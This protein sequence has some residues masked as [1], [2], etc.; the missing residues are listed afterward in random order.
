[1]LHMNP[2][3]IEKE[4]GPDS[5]MERSVV[6]LAALSATGEIARLNALQ[7]QNLLFLL[8]R[9]IASCLGGP[10]FDFKPYHAGPYDP[11]VF[12][13]VESLAEEG[14]IVI[15]RSGPYWTFSVSTTGFEEG[16]QALARMTGHARRYLA[17]A[18]RWILTQ[19]FWAMV[20]G[21]YQQ[22]P[23]MAVN[24]RIPQSTLQDPGWRQRMHPFLAGMVSLV[25]VFHSHRRLQRGPKGDTAVLE[26]DWRAVG[27]DIRLAI[28]H[29]NVA[30]RP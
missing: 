7:V 16:R 21:I 14:K 2:D 24:N 15:D 5:R 1:M 22:Y 29:A 30:G 13:E 23:D 20:S 4:E 17:K 10:H 26:S 11:N 9:E 28:E 6:V 19:P 27:N 12:R 25:E 8:D 3:R 18:S